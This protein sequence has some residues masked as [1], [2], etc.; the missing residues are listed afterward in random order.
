MKNKRQHIVTKAY[1]SAFVDPTTPS[2]QEPYLW[3]YERGSNKPYAS[4]P[5]KVAVESYYYSF[6]TPDGQRD[7]AVDDLLQKVESVAL[8]LLRA[9]DAG[10]DTATLAPE[11]RMNLAHFIALLEVRV[12]RFRT[13][14]EDFLTNVMGDLAI[15]SASHAG[16]FASRIQAMT[17][18]KGTV[19]V[20]DAEVEKLRRFILSKEYK[21][22]INPVVSLQAMLTAAPLV[23]NYI[24]QYEWRILNAP[25]GAAFFTCDGP[26][27]RVTTTKSYPRWQGVGWESPFME[28]TLPLSPR[29]CL[30]ISVHHPEG[31]ELATAAQVRE[32]NHRTAAYAVDEVYSSRQLAAA[33]LP[34]VGDPA[35]WEPVTTALRGSSTEPGEGDA[36]A[37]TSKKARSD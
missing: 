15:E 27:V 8:P 5:K 30:L 1:L 2:G 24:Y 22:N 14:W 29:T 9:I 20:P 33:D 10:R 37:D 31:S 23:A 32:V 26:L 3:V 7:D 17:A 12:P 28:A 6:T 18:E 34:K 11:E 21:L 16:Y 35:C 13:M 36:E 19:P 4:A 25:A